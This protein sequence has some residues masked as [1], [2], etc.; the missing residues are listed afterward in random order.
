MA[1]DLEARCQKAQYQTQCQCFSTGLPL[2]QNKCFATLKNHRKCKNIPKIRK[3][4]VF[5][6]RYNGWQ[7]FK[8]SLLSSLS[9][10]VESLCS[11]LSAISSAGTVQ[12]DMNLKYSSFKQNKAIRIYM[13]DGWFLGWLGIFVPLTPPQVWEN[14]LK[15]LRF[16]FFLKNV[17][18]KE[19][20]LLNLNQNYCP[21]V[22]ICFHSWKYFQGIK[23]K[24]LN[25]DS[26]AFSHAHKSVEPMNKRT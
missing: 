26:S 11:L 1:S 21:V 6:K 13:T 19:D 12:I 7:F 4:N 2:R 23:A 17:K 16:L 24:H 15:N 18:S 5:I 14:T 10:S 22:P 20:Q 9:L 8:Y 3:K 25:S